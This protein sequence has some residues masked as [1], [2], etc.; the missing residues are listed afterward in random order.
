[1]ADRTA[2]YA[3]ISELI[4]PFNK[5]GVE[6]GE[7]TRFADDLQLDS[8]TVMDLVAGIEDEWDIIL[9]LNRLPEI[10]T[11]GQLADAVSEIVDRK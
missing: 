8:L 1:M 10:E 7:A 5:A 4:D 9:P 3:R 6:V 11:V 2:I